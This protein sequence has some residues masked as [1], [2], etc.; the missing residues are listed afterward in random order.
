MKK[1]SQGK[2][3]GTGGGAK[4]KPVPVRTG[5]PAKGVNPGHVSYTGN[6]LGNHTTD[7]GD[8]VLKPTPMHGKPPVNAGTKL[9]NEVALNVNRGGPG[10]GRINHGPSGSQGMHG[11][12]VAGNP[13]DTSGD[14]FPGWPAK[15]GA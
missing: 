3:S 14:L 1:S 8:F 13:M 9:G 7:D 10:A 11:A 2:Q 4:A 6:K 15:R 12:P 5:A